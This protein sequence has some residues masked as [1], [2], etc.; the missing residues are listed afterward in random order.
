MDHVITCMGK[1]AFIMIKLL[2]LDYFLLLSTRL[3]LIAEGSYFQQKSA[4]KP[5]VRYLLNTKRQTD[6]V[7]DYLV[8]IVDHLSIKE[9][10][11]FLRSWRRPT[12][13]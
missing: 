7:S 13:S 4:K 3:F 2:H 1:G 6:T 9:P 5:T 12:Q 11:F 10:I 8:N